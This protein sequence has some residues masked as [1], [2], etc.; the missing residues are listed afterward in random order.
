VRKI[1]VKINRLTLGEPVSL[2]A[3]IKRPVRRL[4]FT[5]KR[6]FNYV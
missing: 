2:K 4:W 5:I 6:W 3:K 1:Y